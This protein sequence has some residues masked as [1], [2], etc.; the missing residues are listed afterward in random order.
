MREALAQIGEPCG[1]MLDRF[2]ARDQSYRTIG[3]ELDLPAGTIA[4]R[5]SR[6]LE[7]LKGAMEDSGSLVS[8]EVG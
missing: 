5:I 3:D 2:Y 6:C 8:P 7:K 1:D 4:S